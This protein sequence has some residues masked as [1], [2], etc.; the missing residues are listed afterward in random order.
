MFF[1]IIGFTFFNSLGVLAQGVPTNQ[2]GQLLWSANHLNGSSNEWTSDGG[3]GIYNTGTGR[4]V[5]STEQAKTGNHSLKLSINTTSGDSHGT[6]IYR[7][8]E[9]G[10]ND[11]L[12]Y[13]FHLYLP[14][15]IDL[16]PNNAWF[17]LVQTKGVKYA[18]GGPGTGPDQINNPHYV[19]GLGV[20]GGAGKGGANFLTLGDLQRFW[21]GSTNVSWAAKPGMDLPTGR[22]VKVQLLIM[23]RRDESG[24][25]ILWQD[26]QLVIDTGLRN[27]LRPEVD[28]NHF[29]INA[30]ADK[31]IP[32]NSSFYLDDV[33]INL[34]GNNS[35]SSNKVFIE[36][37]PNV[38]GSVRI[39]T[40][41]NESNVSITE[42]VNDAVFEENSTINIKANLSNANSPISKVEYYYG[43]NLIGTKTQAP[44]ELNWSPPGNGQ[45]RIRVKGIFENGDSKFSEFVNLI[46]K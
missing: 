14:H 37:N 38:G 24:R 23:Q 43:T 36:S 4:T 21:G 15:R 16:D 46:V 19:V 29:S 30:Y 22:W 32:N 18:A 25:I 39:S 28:A 13:T 17:N 27:T 5:V 31:T 26:D 44:F 12:I 35:S 1:I 41:K 6:R 9:I 34:P 42:P 3:G 11:D 8:K 7:W 33:S 2:L 20:R 10:N 40:Q 45:Y